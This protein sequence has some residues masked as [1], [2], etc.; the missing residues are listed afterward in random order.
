MS[1]R[2]AV[3]ACVVAVAVGSFA[4]GSNVAGAD[5]DGEKK[6]SWKSAN[7]GEERPTTPDRI[8]VDA[9]GDAD[10]GVD[11]Q[12]LAIFNRKNLDFVGLSITGRD[13]RIPTTRSVEVYVGVGS[14]SAKPKYRVVAHNQIPGDLSTVRIYRVNGWTTQGQKRIACGDFKVQFDIQNQS[15]IRMAIPRS[16]IPGSKAPISV[17]ASVWGQHPAQWGERPRPGKD[18]DVVPGKQ[19]LTAAVSLG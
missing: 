18:T 12:S 13:L 4:V 15:Q 8:A 7:A 19:D 1:V 16:C 2:R 6:P 9:L 17:N 5:G 10:R 3:C 11:I 14:K